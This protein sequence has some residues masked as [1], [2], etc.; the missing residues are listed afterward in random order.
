MKLN[1]CDAINLQNCF[2]KTSSALEHNESIWLNVQQ[3]IAGSSGFTLR[4]I[5]T[6]ILT[7]PILAIDLLVLRFSLETLAS[8]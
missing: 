2:G 4:Q 1:I 5:Q 3:G 6:L 8:S 7:A